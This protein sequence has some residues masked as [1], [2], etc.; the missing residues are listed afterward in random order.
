[1]MEDSSLREIIN[2]HLKGD[3]L[4]EVASQFV[5]NQIF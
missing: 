1:M 5:G 4:W 3:F 2:V